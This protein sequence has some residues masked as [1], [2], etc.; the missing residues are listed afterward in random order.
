M[1]VREVAA[2]VMAA[3]FGVVGGVWLFLVVRSGFASPPN[4]FAVSAAGFLIC[5]AVVLQIGLDIVFGK[6]SSEPPDERE[7]LIVARAGN[8]AGWTLTLGVLY[9][10]GR[11]V[12]DGNGN[13]LFHFIILAFIISGLVDYVSQIILFRR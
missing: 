11:Y 6:R 4:S 12:E 1:E 2:W 7:R 3:L 9:G 13:V 8:W 10:L 5:G